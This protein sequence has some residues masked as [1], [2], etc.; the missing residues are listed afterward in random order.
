MINDLF[1]IKVN[2]KVRV[3]R[4]GKKVKKNDSG[5]VKAIYNTFIIL[6]N[7]LYNFCVNEGE[8]KCGDAVLHKKVNKRWEKV[9]Y[10]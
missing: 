9:I 2:D 1:N 10:E 3:T 6:N 7:G 8:L 4:E 5:T